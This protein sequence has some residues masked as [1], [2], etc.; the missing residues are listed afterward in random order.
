M[1][2]GYGLIAA[3][4]DRTPASERRVPVGRRI[5]PSGSTPPKNRVAVIRTDAG[6]VT[7][8]PQPH[9]GVP[10]LFQDG[11]CSSSRS[12]A[13]ITE[14]GLG[15]VLGNSRP[16]GARPDP[17]IQRV[18]DGAC[19]TMPCGAMEDVAWALFETV[20]MAFLGTIGA[21]I[22][23]LPLAFLAARNFAP[24][25]RACASPLRRHLRLR[26]RGR[27]ADL[28]DRAGPRL[29]TRA[30]DRRAGHPAHRHRHLRQDL[31]RGAGK[32]RQ[33]P[34]RRRAVDRRLARSS[35]IASG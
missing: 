12:T 15:Q 2:P 34:G 35:A 25:R 7:I 3:E 24:L 23:A 17:A 32:R 8:H 9:R 26:A 16:V 10:V 28:D 29:R 13:P 27:R 21:A 11:S 4:P 30:A 5:R 22:V 14:V 31:L 20:L 18:R 6:R 33:H 1:V 19:G